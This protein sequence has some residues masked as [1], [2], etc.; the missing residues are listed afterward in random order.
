[1]NIFDVLSQG[2]SRLHEPSISAMLGYLLCTHKDHG[3]GDSFLR[4]FLTQV[5]EKV[6][7]P[8]LNTALER[9]FIDAE[10]DL[11][12]PYMLG[13]SRKDIDIQVSIINADKQEHCRI[14][15]EN[16]IKSGAGNA[17][18]LDEYYRAIIQDDHN[19]QNLMVVFLTPKIF[20]KTLNSEFENLCVKKHHYKFWM[21]WNDEKNGVVNIIKEILQ[22]EIVGDLTPINEYMKHTLK[23]F[24]LHISSIVDTDTG[25]RYRYGEDI[26]NVVKEVPVTLCDGNNYKIILRDSSQI[27]VFSENEKVVAKQILR[28]II[29]EQ[30]L[31]V[32]LSGINTRKMG[33]KV[34]E[35]LATKTHAQRKMAT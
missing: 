5:Q 12:E 2:K 23:A 21:H 9:R 33:A 35:A 26:G 30:R 25:N 24:I 4:A 15:I 10:V 6:G 34:I 1:M 14:I 3:L 17:K 28:K 22:K 7:A 16:R 27:Q 13:N 11:E 18:Q 31:N 8:F 29:K 32:P 20:S 19:L